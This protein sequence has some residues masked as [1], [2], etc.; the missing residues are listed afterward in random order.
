MPFAVMLQGLGFGLSLIL[1]IG[2]QNAFVLR[3]GIRRQHVGLVVA[4]CAAS[5][6]ILIT[7]GVSGAGAVFTRFPE[8][9][10]VAKW[11]GAAFLLAYAVFAA[12]RAIR[13]GVLVVDG[14]DSGDEGRREVRAASD[15][16]RAGGVLPTTAASHGS[17][18]VATAVAAPASGRVRAVLVTTLALTWLNPHV[19]LDAVVLLGS[20][21]STHGEEAWAFGVGA[22]IASIVWFSVLGAG[23]RLLSPLFA[24]P[25]AW[26]I[27]D[28][29]IAVIMT[30]IA[31]NLLLH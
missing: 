14:E 2:A 16:G 25:I 19:Y 17:A 24:R 15:G 13:P 3:Q 8:W 4:V 9:L 6:V 26:R 23:S 5:D 31:L 28:G 11:A 22:S 7:L 29:S 30:V 1:P 20:L 18:P 12:R 27:V 21:A 10:V